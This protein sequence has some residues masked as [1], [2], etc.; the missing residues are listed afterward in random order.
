MFKILEILDHYM[1]SSLF[2]KFFHLK[3]LLLTHR[4]CEAVSCSGVEHGQL[5]SFDGLR[6]GNAVS[7]C[8]VPVHPINQITTGSSGRGQH[9]WTA[10]G[11][12]REG[13]ESNA[14]PSFPIHRPERAVS[15]A[16]GS[17][18]PP[19]FLLGMNTSVWL[20]TRVSQWIF[21]F[22]CCFLFLTEV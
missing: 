20:F 13:T 9:Q 15:R 3:K 21:C 17:D 12:V 1:W 16:R 18:P 4:P 11:E 6:C 8:E 7:V 19:P 2:S 22:C 10:A 14:C 5:I